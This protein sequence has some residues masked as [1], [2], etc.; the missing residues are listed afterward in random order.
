MSDEPENTLPVC[1]RGLD[2]RMDALSTD[3]GDVERRPTALEIQVANLSSIEAS[4]YASLAA[5]PDRVERRL[6]IVPA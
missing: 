4:P 5:R 6:D 3:M 2:A 1:M